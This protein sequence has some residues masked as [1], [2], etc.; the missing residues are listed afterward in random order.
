M[1]EACCRD[2]CALF[3]KFNSAN[4]EHNF[5][6]LLAARVRVSPLHA[7]LP[8]PRFVIDTGR[9]GRDDNLRSDC[10]NWCNIRGAAVGHAPTAQTLL[11]HVRR[12]AQRPAGEVALLIPIGSLR[13]H[14]LLRVYPF[15]V[16]T[17]S[18]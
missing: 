7:L 2:P 1:D 18:V 10:A 5:V 15:T 3:T 16:R 17:P 14:S 6:Q 4:S 13:H 8:D 12:C 9:N 11:P